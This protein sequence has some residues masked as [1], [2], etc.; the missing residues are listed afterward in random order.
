MRRILLFLPALLLFFQ[1]RAFFDESYATRGRESINGVD[2]FHGLLSRYGTVTE[3]SY[4][5]RKAALEADVIIHFEKEEPGEEYLRSVEAWLQGEEYI[6]KKAGENEK[7]VFDPP[8]PA[9]QE[10]EPGDAAKEDNGDEEALEEIPEE[11]QSEVAPGERT[12]PLLLIYFAKDTDASVN[13]WSRVRSWMED[14]PEERAFCDI[15]LNNSLKERKESPPNG[16]VLFGVRSIR[17]EDG[18]LKPVTTI[19][20]EQSLRLPVRSVPGPSVYNGESLDS[21]TIVR[22]GKREDLAREIE[23]QLGWAVI[24]YNSE[25]FLN[26]SLVDKDTRKFAAQFLDYSFGILPSRENLKIAVID[27]SLQFADNAAKKES[28]LFHVFTVFPVNILSAMTALSLLLYLLYRWPHEKPPR[29]DVRSG[30]PEF[31][32]H[33]SALGKKLALSRARLQTLDAIFSWKNVRGEAASAIRETMEKQGSVNDEDM[34]AIVTELQ[35]KW[36]KNG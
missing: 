30:N 7:T 23:T 3:Y 27:N 11:E 13:F 10:S 35:K 29:P 33:I 1:C 20:S 18:P 8:T 17:Y 16:P 31:H 34:I 32:N 19:F 2:A 28:N 9:L 15:Q 26:Y 5:T 14:H 12:K 36:E 6:E 4:L 21:S 25:P 22:A 24:V